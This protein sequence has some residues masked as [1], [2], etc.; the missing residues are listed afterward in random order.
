MHAAWSSELQFKC[1]FPSP[2]LRNEITH[3]SA[4]VLS[5]PPPSTPS[6]SCYVHDALHYSPLTVTRRLLPLLLSLPPSLPPSF[7]ISPSLPRL[8]S[9]FSPCWGSLILSSRMSGPLTST[10]LLLLLSLVL[11]HSPALKAKVSNSPATTCPSVPILQLPSYK[12]R[13]GTRQRWGKTNSAQTCE[14]ESQ[15]HT[16]GQLWHLLHDRLLMPFS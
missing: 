14:Q 3:V 8:S 4:S 10:I 6:P 12:R 15:N 5:S 13:W 2:R 1:V 16:S 7:W 9:S 11:L